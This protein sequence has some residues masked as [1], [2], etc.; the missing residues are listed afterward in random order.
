[1]ALEGKKPADSNRHPSVLAL[2]EK[3]PGERPKQIIRRLAQERLAD[4]C[5]KRWIGPP[6]CPKILSSLYGIR[7]REVDHDIGGE[8][9]I[10]PDPRRP[11]RPMIEYRSG[12]MTERQRFTI[13]HEFAHTLFPDYCV[14]K[15]YHH[16]TL[17]EKDP[18]KEFENLCDVAAAE[19]MMP[20]DVFRADL[21]KGKISG[22][23][24]LTLGTRF[25]AS[26]E[27]TL[28]RITDL[29]TD[30]PI[31]AAFL[32]APGR[33][34]SCEVKYSLKNTLFKKFIAPGS[35][36]RWNGPYNTPTKMLLSVNSYP[37]DHLVEA[38]E[39]PL[40]PE[41]PEYP[42]TALLLLPPTY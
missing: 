29:V 14:F 10:L 25:V 39:L 19:L 27:A 40:I 36:I 35:K 21:V 6:F 28:H 13:F 20:E 37:H 15:T 24:V 11:D 1:M 9:R 7:C 32:M 18:E 5:K 33:G 31:G 30:I 42:R 4:A 2:L 23:G 16:K 22:A 38:L 17:S 3:F 12:R 26:I 8:G 41:Y 34:G